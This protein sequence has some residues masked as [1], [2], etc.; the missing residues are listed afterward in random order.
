MKNKF[1]K[2]LRLASVIIVMAFVAVNLNA[3]SKDTRQV[4]YPMQTGT[5]VVAQGTTTVSLAQDVLDQLAASE[6]SP[7]YTVILTPVGSNSPVSLAEKGNKSFTVQAG[8]GGSV[9]VDYVVMVSANVPRHVAPPTFAPE[10]KM[11]GSTK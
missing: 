3:Q 9:Q 6:T 8:A 11:G 2:K 7:S 4:I 1:F 10:A 5:V